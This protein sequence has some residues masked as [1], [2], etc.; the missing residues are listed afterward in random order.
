MD[1][2][3]FGKIHA[4]HVTFDGAIDAIVALCRAGAGGFVVTPNVDHV[5]LAE[6]DQALVDAYGSAS[7]SLVD[8]KPLVWL[9][10]MMG[11]ALPDKISGSDLVRPLAAR[12]AQE[13]LSLF[14]LGA[15]EGVGA[16]AAQVLV[17]EN[18]GLQIK[19]V[20]SPPVGFERART[21]P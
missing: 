15:Q 20:L 18:P 9:S 14:L 4:H 19:G 16:R 3:P 11:R 6:T 10:Q 8:G 12:A 13:G 2:V 1:S 5:V 17:D 21:P 7:L